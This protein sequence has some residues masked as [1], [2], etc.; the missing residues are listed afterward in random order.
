MRRFLVLVLAMLLPLLAG[1]AFPA[2]AAA[3]P[4]A[5]GP[6]VGEPATIYSL[7]GTATGTITVNSITDP[8]EGY[9]AGNDP[10]SGYHYVLLDVTIAN[11]TDQ[12]LTVNPN[13]V[14]VVDANGIIATSANVGSSSAS[15]SN[16]LAYADVV[17]P[18]SELTGAIA[19]PV[20]D[21]SAVQRVVYATGTDTRATVV[22]LRESF[23]ETGSTATVVDADG[24][25]IAWVFVS[26]VVDPFDEYDASSPPADGSRYVMIDVS[27]VNAGQQDIP[28]SPGDFVAVDDR[29]LVAP[30]APVTSTNPDHVDFVA[31]DVSPGNGADGVIYYQLAAGATLQQITFGDGATREIVIADLAAAGEDQQQAAGVATTA[32]AP[33][34]GCEGLVEW[35]TDLTGR[36]EW[37]G[38]VAAEFQGVTP[39]V[40]DPVSTRMNA[41][42]L[43][44]L[45]Q[46]QRDSNPPPAAE[47]LNTF[48]IEQ[49]MEVIVGATSRLA[50]ALE[51]DDSAAALEAIAEAGGSMA[52]FMPGSEL[53]QHFTDLTA[54]C[55]AEMQSLQGQ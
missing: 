37:F 53:D 31:F 7:D 22:D 42:Q 16:F 3:Q 33:A 20:L 1:G 30:Q 11:S 54:A 28:V 25:E 48:V 8:F 12:P 23:V 6:A 52:L 26:T 47:A 44:I 14:R 21:G 15:G 2:I 55:P 5:P 13:V 34:G 19:Y 17:D 32:P 4:T 18:G 36:I 51:A 24:S 39:N 27:I 43:A 38:G 40:I 49:Y 29:G 35:I 10:P 9:E 50:D 45:T 46:E 41:D